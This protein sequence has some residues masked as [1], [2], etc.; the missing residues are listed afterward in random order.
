MKT[1]YTDVNQTSD[2]KG[3]ITDETYIEILTHTTDWVHGSDY[4]ISVQT[5]IMGANHRY[6]GRQPGGVKHDDWNG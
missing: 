6:D 5:T 2:M 3:L 1:C 4:C